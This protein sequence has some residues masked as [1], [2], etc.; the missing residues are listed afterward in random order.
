MP[1]GEFTLPDVPFPVQ[2][3]LFTLLG[4]GLLWSLLVWLINLPPKT[5]QPDAPAKEQTKYARKGVW[6]KRIWG[7]GNA[8]EKKS[9]PIDKPSNDGN[10]ISNTLA[11]KR[12]PH[13][14]AQILSNHTAAYPSL[15]L[16]AAL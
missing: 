13:P 11:H 2:L 6:W 16:T 1:G 5:F 14:S 3:F 7:H 10:N 4:I 12:V 15:T 9:K 8:V